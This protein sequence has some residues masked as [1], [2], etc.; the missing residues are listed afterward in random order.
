MIVKYPEEIQK[1]V[2]TE[3]ER[4]RQG[5]T[6]RIKACII[7]FIIAIYYI[8]S[9]GTF[10]LDI[11]QSSFIHFKDISLDVGLLI[12]F[13]FSKCAMIVHLFYLLKFCQRP[14]HVE[15]IGSQESPKSS[16]V[17]C[18]LFWS[19]LPFQDRIKPLTDLRQIVKIRPYF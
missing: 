9:I 4:M 11:E 19:D 15:S 10:A 17:W 12:D 16:N 8:V 13:F 18:G 2:D 7:S 5:N 6:C 3:K 14:W 1:P